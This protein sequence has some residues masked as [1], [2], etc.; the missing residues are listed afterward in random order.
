LI[1]TREERD[2]TDRLQFFCDLVSG[3]RLQLLKETD[4]AAATRTGREGVTG[5][6]Q[7]P[8]LQCDAGGG[9]AE[10]SAKKGGVG[11]VTLSF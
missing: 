8:A 9:G 3:G 7:P 10:G 5:R 11:V 1:S 2:R 4:F 6:F